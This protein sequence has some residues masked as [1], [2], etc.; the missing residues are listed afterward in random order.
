MATEGHESE[1]GSEAA[2]H[3]IITSTEAAAEAATATA[4]AA[5]TTASTPQSTAPPS[6]D[7]LQRLQNAIAR[8]K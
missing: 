8:G 5:A 3:V 1:V 7:K 4:Q 2:P 6:R